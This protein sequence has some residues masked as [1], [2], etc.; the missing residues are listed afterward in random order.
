[1]N[2]LHA[3]LGLVFLAS[4]FVTSAAGA[5][6]GPRVGVWLRSFARHAE[7][8][9]VGVL[10]IPADF[11]DDSFN[12]NYLVVDE[13]RDVKR[14]VSLVRSNETAEAAFLDGGEGGRARVWRGDLFTVVTHLHQR[15][16]LTVL[17]KGGSKAHGQ[18]GSLPFTLEELLMRGCDEDEEESRA[19]AGR[20]GVAKGYDRPYGIRTQGTEEEAANIWHDIAWARGFISQGKLFGFNVKKPS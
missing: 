13:P 5:N 12:F 4:V 8:M 7:T 17:F 1:M 18:Q 20:E 11:S 6:G 16:L 9:G 2:Y 10:P 19:A 15:Y 14:L 3:V